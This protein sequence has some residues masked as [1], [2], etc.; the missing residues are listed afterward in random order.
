MTRHGTDARAD[1]ALYFCGM[2]YLQ[3]D[4][5]ATALGDF[6][7]VLTTYPDGDHLPHTLY[8]MSEAFWRLHQCEQARDALET[9]RSG[10]ASSPIAGE[11]RTRL[12]EYRSPPRGYCTEA[13]GSH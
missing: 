4:R 6:R 8:A 3:E 10:Y 12:R 2:S 9:I 5:P 7:R 11:A 1:D 13:G